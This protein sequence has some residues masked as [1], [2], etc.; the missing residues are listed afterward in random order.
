[1]STP[2]LGQREVWVTIWQ[3]GVVL[4]SNETAVVLTGVGSAFQLGRFNGHAQKFTLGELLV[5]D[6]RLSA[7]EA[8]SLET[9]WRTNG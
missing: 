8:S 7:A 2:P 6:R 3:D 1:M 5:Y 9:S 4:A